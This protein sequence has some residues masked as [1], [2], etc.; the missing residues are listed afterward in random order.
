MEA[1]VMRKSYILLIAVALTLSLLQSPAIA[2]NH[3]DA[4]TIK[5]VFADWVAATEAGD[6]ELYASHIADDAVFMGPGAPAVSGKE[7]IVA[8]VA[9]YF[10]GWD[11]S[12]P[13][14]TTHEI[15]VSGDMAIHRYSNVAIF[16]PKG[17][18]DS[19]ELDR[20]NM[21]IL[22]RQPDGRWL[23][24]RHMFNLNR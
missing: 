1:T 3:D 18:G 19:F 13:S 2:D 10:A 7:A 11:F 16:S 14:W 24:Y 5:K 6:V 21:D 12:I 15:I 23:V 8:S 17:G 20:K 22:Q 9:E 4:E